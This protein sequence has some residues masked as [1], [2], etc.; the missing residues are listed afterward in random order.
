MRDATRKYY[1]EFER[2]DERLSIYSL[3]ELR[4]RLRRRQLKKAQLR[5][6]A[7]LDDPGNLRQVARVPENMVKSDSPLGRRKLS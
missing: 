1:S 4:R 3:K 7:G 2:F 6:I 5:H